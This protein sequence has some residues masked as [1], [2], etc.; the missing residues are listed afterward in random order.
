MHACRSL[1]PSVQHQ[2]AFRL[3]PAHFEA[4]LAHRHVVPAWPSVLVRVHSAW[5]KLKF[6]FCIV[7]FFQY[8]KL[9]E[10]I[11]ISHLIHVPEIAINVKYRKMTYVPTFFQEEHSFLSKWQSN[12]QLSLNSWHQNC[13]SHLH[14]IFSLLA[15]FD[16]F[17]FEV[18][19]PSQDSF[20]SQQ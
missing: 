18:S 7:S 17:R 20:G 15:F 14:L 19:L 13:T 5:Q 11:D 2:W 9:K 8:W 6:L 16:C 12:L 1:L 4:A 10:P 3:V